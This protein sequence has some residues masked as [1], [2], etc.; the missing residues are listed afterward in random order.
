M[1]SKFEAGSACCSDC[2]GS[3]AHNPFRASTGYLSTLGYVWYPGVLRTV[4][5]GAI[6]SHMCMNHPCGSLTNM[7]ALSC[8]TPFL[9]EMTS[10]VKI[11]ESDNKF[12]FYSRFHS[13]L[14]SELSPGQMD[15]KVAWNWTWVAGFPLLRGH[16]ALRQPLKQF[17]LLSVFLTY[18]PSKV[19]LAQC[20]ATWF[21]FFALSS[22]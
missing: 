22:L 16:M 15:E 1:K 2:S 20:P 19:G 14:T 17:T 8:T 10:Q 3:Q 13:P 9:Y 21:R 11:A 5:P 4:V 12:I 18:Q 6:P 7:L